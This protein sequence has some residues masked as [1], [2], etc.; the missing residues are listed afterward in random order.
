M[1]HDQEEALAVSDRI[2]VMNNAVVAQDGTPRDLY[3]A[4][5]NAFVA[6]FIGEANIFDCE[7]V[8]VTK[9]VATV[10]LACASFMPVSLAV[11][12]L[13]ADTTPSE[14]LAMVLRKAMLRPLPS[15]LR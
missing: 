11:S 14:Q 4:P 1:T 12:R 5:A 13:T 9:G 10:R 2:I 7:I 6:D 8:S 15:K 3:E